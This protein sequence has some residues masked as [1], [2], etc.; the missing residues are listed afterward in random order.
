LGD[1]FAFGPDDRR[2]SKLELE[3]RQTDKKDQET[4][5]DDDRCCALSLDYQTD[6]L[7]CPSGKPDSGL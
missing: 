3:A 2:A 6:H 5:S 4:H 1:C 7:R